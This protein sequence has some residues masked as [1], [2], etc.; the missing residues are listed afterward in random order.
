MKRTLISQSCRAVI[1]SVLTVWLAASV[2]VAV[3]LAVSSAAAQNPPPVNFISGGLFSGVGVGDRIP[4]AANVYTFAVGDFNK[5]GKLDLIATNSDGN[6]GLILGDGDGTFQAPIGVT[7][8]TGTGVSSPAGIVAADFNQDGDLDFATVWT[9]NSLMQLGVY[10]GDGAGHFTLN[11]TYQIGT[12]TGHTP[13]TIATA[14]LNADG[15]LDL[16]VPDFENSAVAVLYGKGNG[17]FENAVEFPAGVLNQTAPGSVAIGDFNK[18]GKPDIVV[19]STNAYLIL[20]GISVLLNTGSK[21]FSPPVLYTIPTNVGTAQVAV[22]DLNLDRNLDVVEISYESNFVAVFLGIGD[23]TF[24]TAKTSVVLNPSAIAIGDLNG[25]KKPELVVSSAYNGTAYVLLNKGSGNFQLSNIYSVDVAPLAIALADFNGDKKLD[26]I[27]GNNNGQ[28]ATIALGN[29]DGTFQDS[30]HYNVGGSVATQDLAVADFNLD[31]NLDIVQGGGGS[32][33]GLSVMLG[34]PNGVFKAPTFIDLWVWGNGPVTFVR[35]LDIS[36]EGKPDIVCGN[37]KGVVVLLGMGTGK[38]KTAVTY[39]TS[40]TS[41]PVVGSLADLNGDGNLDIVTSNNDGTMSSLLNK[42]SGAFATA[43]VFPSGTGAYPSGFVLGDFTGDGKFDIV[44][45]D[46]PNADLVLLKGNGN[47]TFQSPVVLSSPVR[48]DTMVAADF[49]KDGKLDLTVASNDYSGSLAILLGNGNGSFSSGNV[50]EWFDDSTCIIY[51]ACDHYPLSMVGVDLN[52]DS[53]LDL[54]IAPRN[55]WYI[56][57]GGYR[58]AEEYLGLVVFVGKGDGT[59]VQ[60]S[61]WLAGVSPWWVAAGD[62]NRDGMVDL[63]FVNTDNNYG[64]RSVT[65]LQNATQPLSISPL[66][67]TFAGTRNVGTSISQTVILTNNQSSKLTNMSIVLTGGNVGDFAAKHNCGTAL[68]AGLHCTI[69][70]TFKPLA[71]LTRTTTLQ[72][73]DS[74]GTQTVPLSGVATEVKLSKTS[75]PFGSVTVGQTKTMAV[76]LT[77]IGTS[78]MSIISPGI[79]ITG[80]AAADYSQTNTCGSSVGA[81]QTCTINVTFKPTKKGSRPATLNINDDGGPSPQ[82]VTLSGTGV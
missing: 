33:V 35:A 39:P 46:F 24:Q 18:D 17:T 57:C 66:S 65:I 15:K 73:T 28:F 56:T 64:P 16:I 29:G 11:S 19:S 14:D 30:P 50:Y 13:R 49:N 75:L 3:A 45:G 9:V 34:T 72:I 40:P 47:G 37:S 44:V 80:T 48:P 41:Y 23:G 70:V 71:P 4:G 62:F 54:A 67:V 58:C 61:G 79:V 21:T 31:G 32:G 20:G 38:F 60:Q 25:D 76:T 2:V 82:K 63:A 42:G 52:G 7:G 10:L 78:A 68:G 51:G 55:P 26:F 77:N 22:A 59:L 43:T 53:N 27:A 69:T 6:F 5:D 12:G 36:G 1:Q 8:V 81:G 74:L